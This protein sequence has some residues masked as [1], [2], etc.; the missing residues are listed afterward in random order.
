MKKISIITVVLF[1]FVYIPVFSQSLSINTDGSTANAS[2][3]LD[4]KSTLKGILIPRMTT[5]QKTAIA[6]PAT[7]LQVYD[8]DLNQL[9]FYNGSSWTAIAN[10]SNYWTLSA[11]NIYNNTGT[12]VGIGAVT[13]GEKLEITGNLKF[14]GTSNIY[15]GTGTNLTIRPGDGT[16][17]GGALTIRGGNAGI[18]SGGAGGDLNLV[19]G[20]NLPAGG[21]GYGGL[22]VPGAINILGSSGYNTVGGGVNITA[23]ASSCWALASGSHSDVKI[24]GG[25]NLA[26]T[27]ASSIVLEGGYT[28][29]SSCPPPGA[30]GGNLILKSG[31][32]SGAG[33]NGNIQLLNGNVGIG[34][35]APAY[36]LHVIGD[37]AS[38]GTVR[39]T[40]V[41]VVGA[42]TACSDFRYKKNISPIKNSLNNL[43][44]LQGV[45]YYWKTSEYTNMNFTDRLQIG[46]VAQDVEKLFPEMV[47]TDDAGY[48]SI[49][50]SRLTP[51]LVETIKEQ[52]QQINELFKRVEKLE[53]NN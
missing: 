51:V 28:I 9:F 49:D 36:K 42:I 40:N 30:T 33:T 18:G 34:C 37:I 32:A 27:D 26:V 41:V 17:T 15:C 11:G 43:M 31:L 24:Q 29:G 16:G 35:T 48:K 4:V 39:S 7:G 13:P 44:Q 20:A 3:M 12:N 19:A 25:Q 38:S 8:T 22:G 47:F 45:N 21:A 10:N 52:Q 23:G 14:T 5:A 6:T 46:F 2:A 1:W 50:Y 53:K